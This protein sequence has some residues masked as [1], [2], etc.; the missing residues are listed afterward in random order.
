[1]KKMLLGT[2]FWKS[3]PHTKNLMS[4]KVGLLVV[5]SCTVKN[6]EK[7]VRKVKITPFYVWILIDKNVFHKLDKSIK[8]C[9]VYNPPE[10]SKYCNKDIYDDISL[11]L[12]QKST[13]NHPII[14]M[15]DLNSRTGTLEDFESTAD[16]HT[17]YT[18]GRTTFP[19]P[20]S[21]SSSS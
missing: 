6:I 5:S 10:N 14:I 3:S 20:S 4:R 17:E 18:I 19:T 2:K 12:L 11:D 13:S 8:I 15:G 1:M 21:S 9:V 7:F 16:K